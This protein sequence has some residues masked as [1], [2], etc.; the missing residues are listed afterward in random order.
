M[1]KSLLFQRLPVGQRFDPLA[2]EG[3][4]RVLAEP[5]R[6]TLPDGSVKSVPLGACEIIFFNLS[7]PEREIPFRLGKPDKPCLPAAA[8][9]KKQIR[10]SLALRGN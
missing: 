7:Q 1:A 3:R 10:Q 8:T 5:I 9:T 2:I 4:R 6:K